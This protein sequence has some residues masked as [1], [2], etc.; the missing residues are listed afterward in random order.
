MAV[1]L[2][3]ILKS[4]PETPKFSG[5]KRGHAQV[6]MR[7][8]MQITNRLVSIL[9]YTF[10]SKKSLALLL[11]ATTVAP[12]VSEANYCLAVRGNG[13]LAPAHWGG[14]ARIVET[15]DWPTAMAGGSSA[16]VSM[17]LFESIAMNP[18]L[19]DFEAKKRREAS[20]Y[21]VKSLQS[22]L[23]IFATRPEW[24]KIRALAHDLQKQ[25]GGAGVDFAVWAKT[26]FE[27][28]PKGLIELLIR[29]QTVIENSLKLAIEIGLLNEETFIPLYVA[30]SEARAVESDPI[31]AD[32]SMARVRF[33]ASEAIDAI[34][35]LG[36]FNAESDAN[37]FF[38][39]GVV[40]FRRLANTIGKV[41]NFY[42][43][44]GMSVDLVNELKSHLVECSSSTYGKTW[45]IIRNNR[46]DCD[47]AFKYLVTKYETS[48]LTSSF[49]SRELD[50][51]GTKI[52][53]FP[54][55]SILRL[56]AA[57]KALT[58]IS[59][60]LKALNPAFGAQFTSFTTSENSQEEI[61]FG[62]WGQSSDLQIIEK[63]LS[64]KTGFKDNDGRV[65]NFSEDEKSQRFINLGETTWAEVLS[66]SPA[67]PG[68]APFQVLDLPEG[69]VVSAGGWSDLHP[70]ALL[71]AHGCETTIYL[72]RRGGES[73]FAQ[74]VAKRLLGLEELPWSQISTAESLKNLSIIQN[75]NGLALDSGLPA[76]NPSSVWNR[77]FN[78]ANPKSSFNRALTS[79]EAV[80]CTDWN[81]FDV[82][83][84]GAIS[85]MIHE[86]Y[87]APWAFPDSS[88]M[89]N[90]NFLAELRKSGVTAIG[91]RQN[92]FDQKLGFRPYSGCLAF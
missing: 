8:P 52:K 86:S 50:S 51:V 5:Y 9:N 61:R 74:G 10:L 44:R 90:K 53:I 85:G 64:S 23:E 21:L 11:A 40:N 29:N 87:F 71:R 19:E 38:R 56:S 24:E 83:K 69:A 41:G 14:F 30:L 1:V 32:E 89:A 48:A 79:F 20:S 33:L 76:A 43:G 4:F 78:L 77:L 26:M 27:K 59:N 35:L 46:A 42:S 66:T 84:K 68:L 6:K 31:K 47:V 57:D 15:L 54:T 34:T 39:S 73:L 60:Y 36:K 88:S 37:L 2:F 80:V 13:E 16:T 81:S 12:V 17:F 22:Y 7:G 63:N 82:Q 92:E 65:W 28:D 25:S 58:A 70:G 72:T 18:A 45:E 3:S 49:Q 75:N 55:T 62:Y 67:E 91:S